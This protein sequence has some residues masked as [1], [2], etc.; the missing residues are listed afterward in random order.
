[1]GKS[2]KFITYFGAKFQ[3][4]G[5]RERVGL[6][7]KMYCKEVGCESVDWICFSLG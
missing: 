3:E 2:Y 1:M 7:V 5:S 6:R 4:K